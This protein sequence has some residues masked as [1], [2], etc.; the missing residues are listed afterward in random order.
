MTV[1]SVRTRT[2]L[3]TIMSQALGL[4][5]FNG[6]AINDDGMIEEMSECFLYLDD[7]TFVIFTLLYYFCEMES[8]GLHTDYSLNSFLYYHFNQFLF[9][10]D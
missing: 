4:S 5:L 1:C 7:Y 9:H 3:V 6:H 10:F 8:I 2:F